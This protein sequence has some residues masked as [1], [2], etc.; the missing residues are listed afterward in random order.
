LRRW[1]AEHRAQE[2]KDILLAQELPK[3]ALRSL[4]GEGGSEHDGGEKHQQVCYTIPEYKQRQLQ[5]ATHMSRLCLYVCMYFRLY[6]VFSL[7]PLYEQEY[8]ERVEDD[9][10][11][12]FDMIDDGDVRS[13]NFQFFIPR[14]YVRLLSP[15]VIVQ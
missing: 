10:E 8:K 7:T 13:V 11:A 3:H 1:L 6:S 12:L 2:A 9:E 5:H 14:I 15:S 4:S